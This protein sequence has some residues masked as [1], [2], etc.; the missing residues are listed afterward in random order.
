MLVASFGGDCIIY[1]HIAP[2]AT[3]TASAHFPH[4]PFPFAQVAPFLFP[5]TQ[6]PPPFGVIY[7][8]VQLSSHYIPWAGP[9]QTFP[10]CF[11]FQDKAKSRT[12]C[13]PE[14]G[15]GGP[16]TV[17]ASFESRSRGVPIWVGNN[18]A[19]TTVGQG[20]RGENRVGR[21]VGG[22]HKLAAVLYVWRVSRAIK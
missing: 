18:A 15:L 22:R 11:R 21:G 10:G 1:A 13:W 6:H 12:S 3:A 7:G 8:I 5:S 2:S 17:I 9:A 4:F 14:K 16:S 20:E 19:Q